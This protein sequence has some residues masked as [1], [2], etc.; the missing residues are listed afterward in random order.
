[1]YVD[2]PPPQLPAPQSDA[3]AP[4]YSWGEAVLVGG[5]AE[6]PPQLGTD[7]LPQGAELPCALW[8][9]RR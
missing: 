8:P 9:G 2:L 6:L 7:P 3:C 5:G 1:M 4:L